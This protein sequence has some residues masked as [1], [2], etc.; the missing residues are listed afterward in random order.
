MHVINLT[1]EYVLNFRYNGSAAGRAAPMSIGVRPSRCRCHGTAR[2]TFQLRTC[3]IVPITAWIAP[4]THRFQLVTRN[5]SGSTGRWRA[6]PQLVQSSGSPFRSFNAPKLC[7]PGLSW[8]VILFTVRIS[9]EC[10]F[11]V[12]CLSVLAGRN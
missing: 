7:G 8:C 4:S 12:V 5:S 6:L 3:Y 10:S 2:F 1:R 11:S 9:L